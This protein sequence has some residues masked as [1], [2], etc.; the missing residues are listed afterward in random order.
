MTRQASRRTS[1]ATLE[2]EEVATMR[3]YTHPNHRVQTICGDAYMQLV[4]CD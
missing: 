3:L 2:A 1:R 4:M